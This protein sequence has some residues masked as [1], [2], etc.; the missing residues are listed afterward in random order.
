MEICKDSFDPSGHPHAKTLPGEELNCFYLD[1]LEDLCFEPKWL[2]WDVYCKES[3]DSPRMV[4]L[5]GQI[6]VKHLFTTLAA[7]L[8]LM[9]SA[10][11]EQATIYGT[12]TRTAPGDG[13]NAPTGQDNIVRQST[14]SPWKWKA[15]NKTAKGSRR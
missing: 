15:T 2:S 13:L 6:L 4:R 12:L 10:W 3:A 7:A 14:P 9:G 8:F 11:A 5:S 1:V